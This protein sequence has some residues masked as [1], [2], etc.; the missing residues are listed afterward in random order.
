MTEALLH[1]QLSPLPGAPFESPWVTQ[2]REQ[3][4]GLTV[5]EVDAQADEVTVHYA[6]VLAQEVDGLYITTALAQAGE[7]VSVLQATLRP[8]VRHSQAEI[9]VL[10]DQE[11][12]MPHRLFHSLRPKQLLYCP[13]EDWKPVLEKWR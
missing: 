7:D 2:V 13:M 1:F 4:P 3:F 10:A 8:L 12:P 11:A 9:W 6:K 5:Y